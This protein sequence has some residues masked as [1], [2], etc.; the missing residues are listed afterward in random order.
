MPPATLKQQVLLS[1]VYHHMCKAADVWTYAPG[2]ITLSGVLRAAWKT[3]NSELAGLPQDCWTWLL[4]TQI[5]FQLWM[6]HSATFRSIHRPLLYFEADR[7]PF[8]SIRGDRHVSPVLTAFKVT[9][10]CFPPTLLD[11]ESTY[12]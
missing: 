4:D 5:T 12:P 1:I 7:D 3:I 6:G 11:M 2:G 8:H 9:R 10:P